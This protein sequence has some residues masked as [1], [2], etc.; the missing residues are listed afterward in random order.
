[1]FKKGDKVR[2]IDNSGY[3]YISKNDVHTVL[4]SMTGTNGKELIVINTKFSLLYARR[5]VL[6]EPEVVI[7]CEEDYY[8]WLSK[9]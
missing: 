7:K 8:T 2:C 9:R 1:M 4:E 3:S 6:E 5:F